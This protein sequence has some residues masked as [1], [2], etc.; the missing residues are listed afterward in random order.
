MSAI[1]PLSPEEYQRFADA[2]M[3]PVSEFA[4]GFAIVGFHSETGEPFVL[5]D[6]GKDARTAACKELAVNELLR[7]AASMPVVVRRGSD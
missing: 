6:S 1:E 3:G 2:V 4:D 5:K 7:N